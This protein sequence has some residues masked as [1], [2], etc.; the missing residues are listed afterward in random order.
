MVCYGCVFSRVSGLRQFGSK[1][2]QGDL[3]AAQR[4]GTSPVSQVI[5]EA[6]R[7]G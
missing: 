6:A 3:L 4:A 7:A 1:A 5:R 2:L